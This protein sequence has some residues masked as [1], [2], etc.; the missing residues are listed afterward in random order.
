MCGGQLMRGGLGSDD[1]AGVRN[2][3]REG[4]PGGRNGS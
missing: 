1:P 4:L 3:G 2:A